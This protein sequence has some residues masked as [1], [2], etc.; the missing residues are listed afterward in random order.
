MTRLAALLLLALAGCEQPGSETAAQPAWAEDQSAANA[1]NISSLES[2]IAEL[3]ARIDELEDDGTRQDRN[4]DTL[5]AND[6]GIERFVNETEG[7]VSSVET[8]LGM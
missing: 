5:F 7:R 1:D 2:R 8:R 4:I 6:S 3:E